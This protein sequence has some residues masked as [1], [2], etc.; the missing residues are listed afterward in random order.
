MTEPTLDFQSILSDPEQLLT[1]ETEE[2]AGYLI[3]YLN[4][5]VTNGPPPFLNRDVFINDLLP[6]GIWDKKT[7]QMQR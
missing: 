5:R 6:P 4:D 7:H 2:L 1:L 3:V